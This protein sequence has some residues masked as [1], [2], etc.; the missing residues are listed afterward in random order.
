M[1]GGGRRWGPMGSILIGAASGN[2]KSRT[3]SGVLLYLAPWLTWPALIPI[4]LIFW[5]MASAGTAAAVAIG[6]SLGV[7]GIGLVL[8]TLMAF[9]Q[10]NDLRVQIT[11]G[12]T[13][14]TAVIW[15]FAATMFGLFHRPDVDIWPE[16]WRLPEFV[17]ASFTVQIWG[18]WALTGIFASIIWNINRVARPTAENGDKP[19]E[20]ESP[21]AKALDGARVKVSAV[22]SERG[23]VSGAIEGTPG[24]HTQKQLMD[25]GPTFDSA[26]QLRPGATRIVP[27]PENASRTILKVTPVD[28]HKEAIVFPPQIRH[29]GTSIADHPLDLG[30]Y[31]DGE[32]ATDWWPGEGARPN[33]HIM[34]GGVN[35]AGKAGW[36]VPMIQAMARSDFRFAGAIDVSGKVWQTFGPFVPYV[37]TIIGLH[38][39]DDDAM[40]ANRRDAVELLESIEREAME[41]Q[42]RWGK[43]G[44]EQWGPECFARWGDTFDVYVFEEAQDLDDDAWNLIIR[45]SKKIRS[46]G[47]KMIVVTQR[48]SHTSVPTEIRSQLPG[49][50]CFGQDGWRD[51]AMMLPD[52]VADIL[53]ANTDQPGTWRNSVPGKAI[54][55]TAGQPEERK[56][57]PVRFYNL[58]P[59]PTNN[60]Y[61]EGL[62]ATYVPRVR[63]DDDVQALKTRTYVPPKPGVRTPTEDEDVRTPPRARTRTNEETYKVPAMPDELKDVQADPDEE[64]KLDDPATEAIPLEVPPD[65]V[66]GPLPTAEFRAVVQRHLLTILAEGRTTTTASEIRK[67]RPATGHSRANIRNELLRLQTSA[68]PWEIRVIEP[69]EANG[70]GT[71]VAGEFKVMPP[72]APKPDGV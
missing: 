56:T 24:K 3:S 71:G 42:D 54:V 66:P 44:I 5:W 70:R 43:E 1:S 25:L 37:E 8:Y 13:A 17:L 36:R 51:T 29:A 41:R 65:E 68:E 27:D 12:S 31:T 15:V 19:A 22:D 2:A 55:I 52:D 63:T 69:F 40:D 20:A 50:Y 59:D 47:K 34:V 38:G 7:G 16:V 33:M 57:D 49:S 60:A 48:W 23:L 64:I 46:A 45:L 58:K 35:G 21:L 72:V 6:A 10:R 62:L 9:K 11:A 39:T 4:A 53:S 30:P 28:P 14:G 61:M 18:A 26:H 67:M 32:I